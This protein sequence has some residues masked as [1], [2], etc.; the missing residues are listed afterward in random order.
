MARHETRRASRTGAI[1]LGTALGAATTLGALQSAQAGNQGSDLDISLTP[2]AGGMGGVGLVRPQDPVARQFGNP[3]TLTQLDGQTSMT[4]GGSYLNVDARAEH[5]GSITG[6]PFDERSDASHYLLP[7]VAAQQRVSDDI[8]LGGGIHTITGLGSDFRTASPTVEPIVELVV[9]GANFGGAYDVTDNLT[10]G[11]STTLGFGL[12][13]LGLTSNTGLTHNFG[14]RGS[15]GFTYDFGPVQVG[16]VYNSPMNLS[17]D[18]VTETE[19]DSFSDFDMQQPQELGFGMAT[20]PEIFDNLLLEANV[21]WKNWGG[22]EAYEDIWDNQVISALGGQ[23]MTGDWAL[24]LGYAY[25]TDLQKDDVGGGIGDL[26]TLNVGGQTVPVNEP[27]IQF[28]QATLTQ[29]YWQ[30]QV[31]AGVGYAFTEN[32][33]IDVQAGYAFDG[34]RRIGGTSLEVNEFQAGA[35]VTWNY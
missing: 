33:R 7:E 14:V 12:L 32:I 3:A 30:Q 13:E 19:P 4:L 1:V 8:V 9:F 27:L 28:V 31:S 17:F 22:A 20:T 29:P 24:R 15:A 35:G 23:Y 34:D 11:A 6:V 18:N 2:A 16:G 10:L 21:R 5:D 26:D 25:A